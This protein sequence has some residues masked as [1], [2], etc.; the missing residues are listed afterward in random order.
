M[1]FQ[2]CLPFSNSTLC[3]CVCRYTPDVLN[4]ADSTP[5]HSAAGAG[6]AAALRLL[7]LE[8]GADATLRNGLEE[9]VRDVA[10]SRRKGGGAELAAGDRPL[11]HSST[12][13]FIR[14]F[15]YL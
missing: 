5:M 15:V 3:V 12:R 6:Q 13:S 11:V 7:L 10:V 4:N 9:A 8:G 2:T 1:V 14:S